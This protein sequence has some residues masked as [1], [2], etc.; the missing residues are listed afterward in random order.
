M[1]EKLMSNN[2]EN[3]LFIPIH[4]GSTMWTR[5]VTVADILFGHDK[6]AA[7]AFEHQ[8]DIVLFLFNHP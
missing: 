5:V 3:G 2:F 1:I 8:L 7:G 4:G 6:V